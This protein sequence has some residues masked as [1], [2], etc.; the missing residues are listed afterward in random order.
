MGEVT[1]G[2]W[3][4]FTEPDFSGWWSIRQMETGHEIGSGDGGFWEEDARIMALAPELLDSLKAMVE[5]GE[6]WDWDGRS[7]A[8]DNARAL[9]ARTTGEAS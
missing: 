2:P 1:K 3:K 9:I 8:Q 6:F 5:A 7:V 4:A